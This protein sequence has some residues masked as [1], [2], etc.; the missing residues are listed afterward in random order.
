MRTCPSCF[1]VL[2][3]GLRVCPECDEVLSEQSDVPEECDGT[4]V[5]V[6]PEDLKRIE[7][8]RQRAIADERD[9]KPGGSITATR[10]SSVRHR[11][12][13]VA[14]AHLPPS[15]RVPSV[16]CFA[17]PRARAEGSTGPAS[18]RRWVVVPSPHEPRG[19]GPAL[20]DPGIR[21]RAGEGRGGLPGPRAPRGA[22]AQVPH[23]R[24]PGGLRRVRGQAAAA[25]QQA[26][27]P[28]FGRPVEVGVFFCDV[29]NVDHAPWT[30]EMFAGAMEQYET[31][32]ALQTAGVYHTARG[33]RIV[34]PLERPIPVEE[35][36][37]YIHR[38]FVELERA[39]LRVDHACRDW[40]RHY[41]LPHVVRKG[42]WYR[43]PFVD[44]RRMRPI[45]IE[46]LP[47]PSAWEMPAIGPDVSRTPPRPRPVPA[48]DRS[49][50]VPAFWHNGVQAIADAVREVRSEWHTLFL[51]IAGALSRR[52]PPEHVP[53]LCR[54]IS[55]ASPARSPR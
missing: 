26:R 8:E 40:T 25:L 44:L 22:G 54:A 28:H 13:T 33:R 19:R 48:I 41:R 12:G 4:L 3:L 7:L 6:R 14:G 21:R 31:L 34:Q 9:Y 30:D 27:L 1:A 11:R 52:V 15:T 39:G 46:P 37:P 23:R 20:A 32:E 10:R 45:A 42:H 16:R 55:I 49:A 50:E 18:R 29:D 43:S 17:A 38:W 47:E 51:A 35:V 36:E 24:P 2:P 5:E 53:A